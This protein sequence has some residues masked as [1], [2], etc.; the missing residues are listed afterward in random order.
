MQRWFAGILTF[1]AIGCGGNVRSPTAPSAT[2]TPSV[3]G[4]WRGLGT[5]SVLSGTVNISATLNQTG[6]DVTGT[7]VC[8]PGSIQC[9]QSSGSI[10]GTMSGTSLTA[11]IVFADTSSCGAFNGTLSGSTLSGSYTCTTPWG[12]D[13]GTWQM[14]RQ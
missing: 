7:Y 2:S 9:L 14:V 13:Q 4:S 11:Q 10:R 3:A 6:G 5:S 1:L 12:S 8:S